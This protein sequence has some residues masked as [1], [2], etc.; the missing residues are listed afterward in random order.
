[1]KCNVCKTTAVN[2][3]HSKGEKKI[4]R[5]RQGSCRP[6]ALIW[7]K[8]GKEC[9]LQVLVD[10]VEETVLLRTSSLPSRTI[11]SATFQFWSTLVLLNILK[12]YCG[13]MLTG[14][15]FRTSSV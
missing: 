1:M 15:G 2:V 3:V 14:W 11:S 9:C 7:E 8:A 4:W 5:F 13:R 10:A 6:S 12:N